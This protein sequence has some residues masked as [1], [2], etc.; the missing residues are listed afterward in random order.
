MH[1]YKMHEYLCDAHRTAA[2]GLV[3]TVD[4]T[5]IVHA[6][7]SHQSICR[8]LVGTSDDPR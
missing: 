6:P 3:D 2:S 5:N 4:G 7:A 8:L 1:E